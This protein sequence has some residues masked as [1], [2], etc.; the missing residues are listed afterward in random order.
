MATIHPEALKLWKE[1]RNKDCTLCPLHESAQTVCLMGD[2]PVKS[3]NIMIIGEAPGFR[4]DEVHKPFAGRSGQLLRSTL[5]SVGIDPAKCYITNINKC[6]PPDNRTPKASEATACRVYLEQELEAVRPDYILTV[7]NHA[8]KLLKKGGIMK[9]RGEFFQYGDAIVMPTIHPAGVLRNPKWESLFKA[10]IESFGRLVKGQDAKIPPPKTYLIRSRKSLAAA[11]KLVMNSEAVAYDIETN[12]FDELDEDAQIVSISVSPREGLAFVL[13]VFHPQSPWKHPYNVLSILGRALLFTNAKL[14]AHN[15][16]FDDRWLHQFDIPIH[17]D[18]DTILAAHLLDENRLKS[19]KALSQVI[20]GVDAYAIDTGN[21]LETPMKTI[22]RYNAKDTDYTLRL[23]Y[24]FR[25]ELKEERRILRL[26]KLL[27]MPA[28]HALTDIERHGIWVDNERLEARMIEVSNKLTKINKQLTKIFGMEANWNST[29]V[30]A[31]LLFG[32]LKLP[33]IEMTAGGA[34][35]T[36]ESVLLR[37]RDKHKAAELILDWRKYSKY[38]STYLRRWSEI[39]HDSRLHP[40]YKIFGTVTG[41]LSSGKEDPKAKGLN[42]QQVPR[43]PLIRGILG[44]PP[45]WKFV[46]AD[47]S[48]IE[49]RIAAEYSGDITMQRYFRE[50]RDI[51]SATA[52]RVSGVPEDKLTKE[53]R[54]KGKGVNFGYLF[55]MGWKKFIDYARDSYD[56][57]FTEAESKAARKAFFDEFAQLQKWHERQ[58]R[59][60]NAYKRVVSLIGRVRHLPDIDSEDKEVRAE[61][62]R[63]A[64]N[65]PV[66]G[67]ASDMTLL[68][69]IILHGM[70]DPKEAKIVATVHDSILFEI[71]DDVVDKWA[72]IIKQTMENLPLKKKFGAELS[73]PV[74]VDISVGQHWGEGE[75]LEDL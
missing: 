15:A 17:A 44:A 73:V 12:G 62:E 49:L 21:L 53:E 58:R 3:A 48:Q 14:I 10:D 70:M 47:F 35:S 72:P 50:G 30:L 32:K 56:A 64:I 69:I 5:K 33:L 23:Y 4:E 57:V 65:S 61:A 66:Q 60:A 28:S 39:Q 52:S 67:L 22:A 2:G 54:K 7:G 74:K 13:P 63:Q 36:K 43:D 59:L 11:V 19:L 51:H 20:L 37:L 1:V 9:H 31:E 6:R 24:R 25:E 45:G 55:G 68:S 27:M 8:L 18:F 46:E 29:K 42:I 41:R 40:N 34:P 75:E 38:M 71:R 26:F 16:K